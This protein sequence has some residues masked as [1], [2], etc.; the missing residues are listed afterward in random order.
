MVRIRLRRVGRKKQ[1]SYRIVVAD[2]RSP[3]DGRYIE[4]IGFYNPRTEPATMTLK[5]DRALHWLENGAQP[6]ETVQYILD[7]MGTQARFERLMKGEELEKLLA[8]AEAEAAAREPV[9]PKTS[10]TAG[11]KSTR[12]IE[13]MAAMAAAEAEDTAAAEAAEAEAETADAESAADDDT[14]AETAEADDDAAESAATE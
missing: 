4:I 6:S 3:R 7:T 1:P 10:I 14:E 2:S 11:K 5:E 8:E 13:E 12:K 9:S